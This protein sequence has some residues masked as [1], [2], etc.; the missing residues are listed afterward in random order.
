MRRLR[1][2]YAII[3]CNRRDGSAR[4]VS[5]LAERIALKH[6]VHLFARRAEEID[7][8]HIEWHRMPG[9]SWPAV[10]D[11]VTYHALAEFTISR[12]SF[13]IVHSV[14]NAMAANVITIQNI[15]PAKREAMSELSEQSRISIARRFTRW[16]YGGCAR[17]GRYLLF[18][19]PI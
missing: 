12:R 2:A 5:E 15:Q 9:L 1:I 8:S 16:L 17:R 10:L 6:E 19:K 4:A 13:D 14:G 11:F 18:P 3:N 7:L